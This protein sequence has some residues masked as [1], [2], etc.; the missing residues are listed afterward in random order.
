M[1]LYNAH[2]A[3]VRAVNESRPEA[4]AIAEARLA[5]FRD[6]AHVL[7][8]SQQCGR[9][10]MDADEM[11]LDAG[12]DRPMCGGVFLDDGAAEQKDPDHA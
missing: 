3:L 4:R 6:C 7:L 10:I 12:I 2:R 9:M 8:S 1:N 11:Y 5:G